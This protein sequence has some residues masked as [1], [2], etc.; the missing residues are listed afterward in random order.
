MDSIP[1]LVFYKD[2]QS[3]YL[4]CNKAFE[5][6]AGKTVDE[7]V[8]YTDFD[9]F[10]SDTATLFRTMDE[11]ML[12]EKKSRRNEEMVTYPDGRQVYLETLKTPYYDHDGQNLGLIGISR[13]I[14]ERKQH[15][16][17]I[18]YL[19]QH[20][21]LTGLHNRSYYEAERQRLDHCDYLPLSLII[22][23]INGLKLINDAF[24]HSEG[25]KLLISIARIMADC[26]RPQDVLVRTGGD[27]FVMLLPQTSY[28]EAGALVEKLKSA[29]EAGYKLDNELIIT[30][31]SLGFATKT[32]A[33][34]SLE[35]VFKL[36]EE[37]MY[38]K[39]L[40]EYKS[41][42]SAV[43]ASIK[44]TL[45]EKSNET[46]AHA[47]RMADLAKQLGR[48]LGLDQEELVAL[49]LVATLHDIGKISIDSKLLKKNAPL[50]EAEWA[51]I[52]KHPEV[53]Y[54]IAQTVP[55]LRKIAEYILC[56]HERWDGNG[57]PQGLKGVEIPLLA[58]ILAIV[59][60]YD[61]M[62]QNR[63]Y[64][65]AMVEREAIAELQRHAGS[66]FDPDLVTV[67]IHEV[68]EKNSNIVESS[69]DA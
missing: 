27:E 5:A 34:E 65:P 7:L 1:D 12:R 17:E 36:A 20:D 52:K 22:G 23:D 38:R 59:D 14:T 29:C 43:M 66:Q 11:I 49:E 53:G 61:A 56:H 62:T 24:G 64:R 37:S 32:S 63:S 39:K 19:G 58:R 55:E 31:I 54:R 16:A 2:Q 42:H 67:F 3:V 51:E 47:E 35:K 44:T 21:A 28:S 60:A 69:A 45:F 25:D 50:T 68:I 40:L 33:H 57:Y 30:S 4:G 46:E 9:L 10:D 26:A 6:F 41:F 15:E 8:G 48:V 18:L 13:D